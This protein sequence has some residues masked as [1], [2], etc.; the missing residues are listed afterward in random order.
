MT[1]NRRYV[2]S[3]AA[4]TADRIYTFPSA[5]AG[6]AIEIQITAGDDL[7]ELILHTNGGVEISRLFITDEFMRWE[8]LGGTDWRVV[9]DGRIP[10]VGVL[11]ATS[12]S[13]VTGNVWTQVLFNTESSNSSSASH[14][15][16]RLTAR[17]AGRYNFSALWV[18]ASVTAVTI[19]AITKNGPTVSPD[20]RIASSLFA[21]STS[22]VGTV[23]GGAY[24]V[25]A[26][27][28]DVGDTFEL[29][30]F[31][32]ATATAL[33]SVPYLPRFAFTEVL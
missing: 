22:S 23:S 20:N 31:V 12:S 28:A 26:L 32:T 21:G 17:R 2:G 5:S 29:L 30:V 27:A 24:A 13:S 3:I 15:N 25:Q 6:D 11:E 10:Q 19:L 8:C 4:F 1:A 9:V 33:S 18:S 16:D 14:A 7:Y